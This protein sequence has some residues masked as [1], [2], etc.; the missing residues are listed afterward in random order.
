MKTKRIDPRR[1]R[2]QLELSLLNFRFP[3]QPNIPPNGWI[4]SLRLA[5]R[6]TLRDL[7][8]RLECRH[9]TVRDWEDREISETIQL[10]T[11]KNIARGMDCELIYFFAPR[12][13]HKNFEDVFRKIHG[14]RRPLRIAARDLFRTVEF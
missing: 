11:L 14:A 12:P 10:G 6:L 7:A 5:L 1:A 2:D 8:K 4:R 13:A 9:E 3:F